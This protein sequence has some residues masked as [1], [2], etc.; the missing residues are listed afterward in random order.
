MKNDHF[1]KMFIRPWIGNGSARKSLIGSGTFQFSF[2]PTFAIVLAVYH[3]GLW[4]IYGGASSLS[5]Q[6]IVAF[7]FTP[8]ILNFD[9]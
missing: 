3:L 9:L 8:V 5:L 1:S 6:E 4:I 2:R 7:F